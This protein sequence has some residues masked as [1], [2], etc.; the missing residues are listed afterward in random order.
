MS[1]ILQNGTLADVTFDRYHGQNGTTEPAVYW[2]KSF[3]QYIGYNQ[4]SLLVTRSKGA[5]GAMKATIKL[6][7]PKVVTVDGVQVK[8]HD[9][10]FN[11][12][13]TVPDTMTLAERKDLRVLAAN[14]LLSETGV[15]A[16]D[17]QQPQD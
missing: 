4:L 17:N 6:V 7:M 15:A 16:I 8:V 14:F 13:F 9:A 1:I 5:K 10:I 3:G 12:S 11:A 2:D